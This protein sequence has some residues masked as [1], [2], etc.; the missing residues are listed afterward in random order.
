MKNTF[1][2]EHPISTLQRL[3]ETDMLEAWPEEYRHAVDRHE[4]PAGSNSAR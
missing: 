3:W 2:V 4:V 1:S